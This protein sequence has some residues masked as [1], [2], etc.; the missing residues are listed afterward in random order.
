MADE[1]IIE[2]WKD[3]PEFEGYYQVSNLGRVRS[4][5]RVIMR[6]NG[7]P[8][9][10]R[11]RILRPTNNCVSGYG[12]ITLC[13][14]DVQK[15]CY[16]HRVLGISFG[17]IQDVWES[18]IDHRDRIPFNDGITN[19]RQATQAQNNFNKNMRSDNKSGHIGVSWARGKWEAS[20]RIGSLRRRLRFPDIIEAAMQYRKWS[21]ELHGEFS[22][23][24]NHE[25]VN[26][27]DV[28][29]V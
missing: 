4:I 28:A 10:V 15:K 12:V 18:R 24:L 1:Q 9:T 21:I 17:L 26:V 14:K 27:S 20:I 6:G 7:H 16:V 22:P 11:A 23:F 25:T 13:K 8:Q 3:I 5:T 19:L 2:I 29:K